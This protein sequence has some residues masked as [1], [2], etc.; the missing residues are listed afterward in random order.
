M[1]LNWIEISKDA[2][3]NNLKILKNLAPGKQIL[4]VVKSNAYGHGLMEVSSI[5]NPEVDG[6]VV[7]D[8]D[9][10]LM[11]TKHITKPKRVI[12][13]LPPLDKDGLET[14]YERNFEIF[15]G[16]LDFLKFIEALPLKSEIKVHLEVNTGM[17]RSGISP[18]HVKD[19]LDFIL[20]SK[21][22]KLVGLF[23]HFATLPEDVEFAKIQATKFMEVVKQANLPPNILIHMEN[24]FGILKYLLE[25]TN[26]VRPGLS[27]YGLTNN[28]MGFRPILSLKSR[29]IDILRVK[30]GE[31]ISY[32]HIFKADR[33]MYVATIPFGYGN[34]YPWNLKGK[35]EVIVKGK[36]APV[37][38]KICMNH[39]VFDVTGVYNELKIG[40]VVTLIG[41]EGEEEI[42]VNEL[43]QKGETI[44]YEIVSRL[45]PLIKR[46][47]V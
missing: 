7:G 30:K 32:D 35:A 14:V 33:D 29:I 27:I 12:I 21:N 46:V 4:A 23:S 13:S 1:T 6:F 42:T 8:L 22:I 20:S 38:G 2:L 45:S 31:G 3:I 37:L 40:D 36:R 24:S 34:G 28:H 47:I 26:G 25:I 43:A 19:S 10:A 11:L 41:R 17:N 44:N 39:M 15:A 18:E 5:L 16:S 9:E